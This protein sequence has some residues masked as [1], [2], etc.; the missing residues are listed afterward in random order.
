MAVPKTWHVNPGQEII[1]PQ[2]SECMRGGFGSEVWYN[3]MLNKSYYITGSAGFGWD[4][5]EY[6]QPLCPRCWERYAEY[7]EERR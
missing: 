1:L 6:D 5:M 3:P 2:G 7:R 4:I